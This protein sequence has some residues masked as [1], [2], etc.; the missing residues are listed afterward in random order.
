[1]TNELVNV[2]LALKLQKLL[3]E[4]PRLM[5]MLDRILEVMEKFL[6]ALTLKARL[7]HSFMKVSS[8]QLSMT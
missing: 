2:I 8:L 3:R 7:P 4:Q 5:L 6:A 1:M